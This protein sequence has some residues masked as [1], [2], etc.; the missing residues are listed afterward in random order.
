M[1]GCRSAL[2]AA[3]FERG[4]PHD[5]VDAYGYAEKVIEELTDGIGYSWQLVCYVMRAAFARNQWAEF[6]KFLDRFQR[7]YSK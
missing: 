2:D 4:D 5:L 6:G 7:D 1:R 3:L